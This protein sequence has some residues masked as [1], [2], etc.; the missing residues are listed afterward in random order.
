LPELWLSGKM[1]DR[2]KML[3]CPSAEDPHTADLYGP[4]AVE[5]RPPKEGTFGVP[6][7]RFEP[8]AQ[9]EWPRGLRW[10][11]FYWAYRRK[12]HLRN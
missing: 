8:L 3:N 5:L 10:R 2:N 9:R 1:V 12:R 11:L 7:V 6:K 4:L